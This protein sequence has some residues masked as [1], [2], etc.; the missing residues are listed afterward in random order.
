MDKKTW[1][2]MQKYEQLGNIGSEISRA[3]HW[4]QLNHQENYQKSLSRALSLLFLSL[5]DKKWG[6]GIKEIARFYEVLASIYIDQNT[7]NISLSD[8]EDFCVNFVINS[9]NR[10]NCN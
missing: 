6:N 2:K 7:I 3:K 9:K 10:P 5:G 1:C 8:L 4:Q